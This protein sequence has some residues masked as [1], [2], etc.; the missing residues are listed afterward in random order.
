[1]DFPPR[2][3]CASFSSGPCAK[4]PGWSVTCLQEALVGRSHRSLEAIEKLQTLT[5]K[6]RRLLAVP[7]G[8]RIGIFPG[9]ATG[10]V[11]IAFWNFLGACGV[12]VFVWDVFSRIWADDIQNQ[13]CLDTRV[14]SAPF[15]TCPDLKE[16]NPQ[17]DIVFCWTGTTTCVSVPHTDWLPLERTGLTFCD[18]TSAAFLVDLP[19]KKLDV[20]AFSCQKVLG[21]EACFSFLIFSPHAIDRLAQ[22]TPVWPIPRLMQLK[23]NEKILEKIF[24]GQVINTISLLVVE[25]FSKALSW[26]ED[27]GGIQTLQHLAQ[28]NQACI[29]NWIS[30]QT[31]FAYLVKDPA[32]RPLTPVG[33]V[34]T[35]AAFS[36]KS[37]AAQWKDL[38]TLTEILRK[39][40][41]AFDVLGHIK[42]VPHLRFWTGPTI[43]TTD[44]ACALD[45]LSWAYTRWSAAL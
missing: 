12:D 8:Y 24:Q 41:I 4:P 44:L 25:D 3:A 40:R 43:E 34:P 21:G 28:K 35:H 17:R 6:V 29:K 39:E 33:F 45:G 7:D 14:F 11:E 18:A 2:P 15:G 10:A 42:S 23:K 36:N 26:V 1:M 13:L 30:Q 20:T 37:T 32:V 27:I 5:T 9:S 19:W 38:A 31:D 16:A 22:Y